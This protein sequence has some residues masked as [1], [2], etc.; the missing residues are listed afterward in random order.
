[1]N[2]TELVR[3]APRVGFTERFRCFSKPA[4]PLRRLELS[5]YVRD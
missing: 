5:R 3:S 4:N 1:M 2:L